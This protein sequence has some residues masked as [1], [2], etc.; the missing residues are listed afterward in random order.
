MATVTQAMLDRLKSDAERL[1]SRITYVGSNE[2][3]KRNNANRRL[4]DARLDYMMQNA[5]QQQAVGYDN[6]AISN[7]LS[8]LQGTAAQVTGQKPTDFTPVGQ[9]NWLGISAQS[10][11]PLAE[12]TASLDANLQNLG[13]YTQMASQMTAAD[14]SAKLAQLDATNPNWRAER[15]QA[16][17]INRS[18]MSGE[19]SK[20]VAD[21]IQRDAAFQSLMTGGYGG[22][23]NA[24]AVTARDLGITGMQLQQQ[25][26]EASMKWQQMLASLLPQATS[27]ASVAQTFGVTAKDVIQTALQNAQQ[28]LTAQTANATG[29]LQAATSNIDTAM[30]A[31]ELASRERQAYDTM[32]LQTASQIADLGT[33]AV[34]NRYAADLN[35]SNIQYANQYRPWMMAATRF[36][37]QMGQQGSY[38]YGI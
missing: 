27:S 23:Q 10:V 34:G 18:M 7:Y 22:A 20:D 38:G 29:M 9:A 1:N 12:A 5:P 32:K 8:Q 21:K 30:K 24:R 26:Q 17:A 33:T 15:D 19:V 4:N 2:W 31:K 11:N 16:A 35:A 6:A 37:N 13:K 28:N 36:G 14:T 25:G 3:V